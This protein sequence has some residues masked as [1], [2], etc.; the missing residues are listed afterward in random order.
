MHQQ[1]Q[2]GDLLEDFCKPMCNAKDRKSRRE[3]KDRY[4]LKA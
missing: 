2:Q 3:E 1:Q 4:K